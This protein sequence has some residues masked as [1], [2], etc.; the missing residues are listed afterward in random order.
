MSAEAFTTSQ[1]TV[2]RPAALVVDDDPDVRSLSVQRLADLGFRV[3]AAPNGPAALK[4]LA[5]A[6]P[7]DLVF[8]DVIMPGGMTGFGVAD[9]AVARRP[10]VKIMFTTG[11]GGTATPHG[12]LR[13]MGAPMLHKPY[14]RKDL[15]RAIQQAFGAS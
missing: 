4:L 15:A 2:R 13:H 14:T 10:G 12:Q 6:E 5:G 9:A 1:Q 11:Y 3:L 7:I 8:T